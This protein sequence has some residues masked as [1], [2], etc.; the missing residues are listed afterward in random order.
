MNQ[1]P[2][3]RD[4][5][6]INSKNL[7]QLTDD[8]NNSIIHRMFNHFLLFTNQEHKENFA[9]SKKKFDEWKKIFKNL[10]VSESFFRDIYKKLYKF[11]ELHSRVSKGEI[12]EMKDI[13]SWKDDMSEP[14]SLDTKHIPTTREK[15]ISEP[16]SLDTE[17]TLT[18]RQKSMSEPVSLDTKTQSS[19]CED[20]T[21]SPE[22][23]KTIQYFRE[24]KCFCILGEAGSGK[25]FIIRTMYDMIPDKNTIQVT[26]YTGCAAVGLGIKNA[27][28]L[29]SFLGGISEIKEEIIDNIKKNNDNYNRWLSLKYLIVDEVS[30]LKV[31]LF[32]VLND[33]AQ[34]IR[35]NKKLMGGIITIFSGDFYQLPPIKSKFCFKCPLWNKLF[36]RECHIQYKKN[37]RQKDDELFQN[38]LE[39]IRNGKVDDKYLKILQQKAKQPNG[40]GVKLFAKRDLVKDEN[41][42][43]YEKLQ[44]KEYVFELIKDNID[45]YEKSFLDEVHKL[46][47]KDSAWDDKVKL[48]VGCKVMLTQ[49]LSI[50]EGL[51]NGSQGEIIDF[52]NGHPKVRFTNGT[53]RTI[54]RQEIKSEDYPDICISQ[55]PLILSY[56]ITIHKAQGVTLEKAT[57]DMNS[58]FADEHAYV[59]FS[60]V[61]TLDGL[62]INTFN[63]QKFIRKEKDESN[64]VKKFYEDIEKNGENVQD[65]I[66]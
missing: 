22:Q 19:S 46:L 57:I 65:M 33:V 32:K 51:C 43:E 61:K 1:F 14:V 62:S 50:S 38:I 35:G 12:W 31:E 15:S 8:G 4:E 9:I 29:H 13:R 27:K 5:E 39:Q 6:Y 11:P 18:T 26:A 54:K 16:V 40:N 34:E 49:N 63:K 25:S 42:V 28:T 20:Y 24:E 23:E 47:K 56:A 44:T 64:S 7:Q 58:M 59:A 55:I 53:E 66:L 52:E 17:D 3:G 37:F 2:Q 30:M 21:L 60:R 10:N 41:L 36:P 48:K 45:C